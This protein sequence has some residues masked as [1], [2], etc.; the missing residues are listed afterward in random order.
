MTAA[1]YEGLQIDANQQL[2]ICGETVGYLM[3]PYRLLL[4]QYMYVMRP[5]RSSQYRLLQMAGLCIS[6][7]EHNAARS[8]IGTRSFVLSLIFPVAVRLKRICMPLA[9]PCSLPLP[10]TLHTQQRTYHGRNKA[11]C[12]FVAVGPCSSCWA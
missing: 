2:V 3:A 10:F 1:C 7:A 8:K 9:V 11:I 5:R 12:I 4:P 6:Q